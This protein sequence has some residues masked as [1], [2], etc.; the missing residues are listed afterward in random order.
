MWGP[1]EPQLGTPS[2]SSRWYA[3]CTPKHATTRRAKAHSS[4]AHLSENA[5]QSSL[6]VVNEHSR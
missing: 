5:V 3:S 6:E 2:R 1:F 4:V